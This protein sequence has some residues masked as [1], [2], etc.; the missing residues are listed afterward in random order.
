M[1]YWVMMRMLKV[2]FWFLFRPDILKNA[3]QK[4]VERGQLEQITGK[5]ATGTFQVC[6]NMHL[7]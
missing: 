7:G 2:V 6:G 1:L 4:A 3:L 5:G